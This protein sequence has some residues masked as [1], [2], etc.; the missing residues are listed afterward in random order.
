V[1]RFTGF[2]STAYNTRISL[3]SLLVGGAMPVHWTVYHPS[4]PPEYVGGEKEMSAVATE[5]KQNNTATTSTRD[6]MMIVD[7]DRILFILCQD[8]IFFYSTNS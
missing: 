4:S 2:W 6:L 5:T 1:P 3:V 8:I 7:I